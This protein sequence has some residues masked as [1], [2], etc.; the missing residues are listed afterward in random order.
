MDQLFLL[1]LECSMHKTHDCP[2]KL[3][4]GKKKQNLLWLLSTKS[5][6]VNLKVEAKVLRYK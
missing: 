6:Q 5:L 3:F 4:F 2:F 1:E